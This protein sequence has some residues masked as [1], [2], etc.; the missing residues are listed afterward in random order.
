M[1]ITGYELFEVPPRW[2]F[3]KLETDAGV[4][5]WGEPIVEGYAKTTKA[6][7]SEVAET[8]CLGGQLRPLLRRPS[9]TIRV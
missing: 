4:C 7:S 8:T 6:A 9:G 5:G 1:E 3:L 2:V